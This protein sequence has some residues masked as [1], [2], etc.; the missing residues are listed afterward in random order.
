MCGIFGI[1][2]HSEAANLTYL[3]LHALQHRGQESAGIVSGDG[4]QLHVHREMGL[5]AGRLRARRPGRP[6]PG[7]C[8]IGHVRYST[9]GV[10]G[11]RTPSRSRSSTRAARSPSPTTATSPTPTSCGTQL[12]AARRHLPGDSATPRSSSTSWRAAALPA[13]CQSS[14]V[15]G[16]LARCRA[17][18]SLLFLTPEHAI[19]AVR[20][21]HGF[22]PLV[23]GRLAGRARAS[24]SETTAL[25]LIE[26][27]YVSRGRAGRD[28]GRRR[29]GTALRAAASP[30][31]AGP[32]AA[33]SSTSTSPART[34]TSSG[35]R[36][37]RRA[38]ASAA[39]SRWSSR[40]R[41]TS[42]SPSPT[43]A[44][45]R[46]SASP[47]PPA[48]PSTSGLIRSHYVGRTFIEPQQSIRHFG[49]KLKL[50]RCARSSRASAWWS[51]TTPSCAAPPR[52]RSSR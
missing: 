38:S 43:P 20:D 50:R 46:R 29:Q 15:R 47:R 35:Q 18:Y 30:R 17:R 6:W 5:V 14:I 24:P 45:P 51:S 39:S 1:F 22:R 32:P 25:D 40:R 12:E 31:R 10:A 52:A 44:S 28:G 9:A 37:T 48:S 49:V 23:L 34:R 26:A 27:E 3:G 4:Q 11:T 42:S 13:L 19:V 41:P 36:S 2:G 7:D 8:A 21:P 16:A 33:S